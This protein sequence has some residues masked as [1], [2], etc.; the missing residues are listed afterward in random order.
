LNKKD[1]AERLENISKIKIKEAAQSTKE[2]NEKATKSLPT[3][4][5]EAEVPSACSQTDLIM[6]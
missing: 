6:V 3:K 4:P 5:K 2:V 1:L